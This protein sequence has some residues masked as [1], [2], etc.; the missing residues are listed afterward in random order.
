M[1]VRD[2]SQRHYK[3]VSRAVWTPEGK[4]ANLAAKKI[5]A[6]SLNRAASGGRKM[7]PS[8]VCDPHRLARIAGFDAKPGG[9]HHGERFNPAEA[10]TVPLL[11]RAIALASTRSTANR[12]LTEIACFAALVQ[13]HSQ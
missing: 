5:T 10:V 3:L 2:P 6:P 13:K 4:S 11:D 9:H 8:S 12:R 1:L 7:D